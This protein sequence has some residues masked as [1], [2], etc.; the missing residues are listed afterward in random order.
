MTAKEK[1]NSSTEKIISFKPDEET[2]SGVEK[3][4]E[5]IK[6]Q[7]RLLQVI[8]AEHVLVAIHASENIAVEVPQNVA[9]EMMKRF[10]HNFEVYTFLN[11]INKSVALIYDPDIVTIDPDEA[12]NLK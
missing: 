7:N 8:E 10:A 2:P 1:L 3:Y 4:N 6:R 9:I 12:Y 11:S 5:K